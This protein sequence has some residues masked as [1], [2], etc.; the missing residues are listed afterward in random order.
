MTDFNFD[1]NTMTRAYAQ[2]KAL[3]EE[4]NVRPKARPKGIASKP[5]DGNTDTS[6]DE[7]N[8]YDK[9]LD[10]LLGYF[11]NEDEADKV[12]SDKTPDRQDTQ[13]SYEDMFGG[14]SQE[15]IDAVEQAKQ[16]RMGPADR[17]DVDVVEKEVITEEAKPKPLV[18]PKDI[19][20][21]LQ[22]MDPEGIEDMPPL[23]KPATDDGGL[24]SR[25]TSSEEGET[26]T[27]AGLMSDPRKLGGAEGY[28]NP[29]GDLSIFSTSVD[30]LYTEFKGNL[31]GDESHLG[32]ADYKQI[33]ITLPLGIVATSGLKY[34]H[35]GTT[36][37]LPKKLSNR[38]PVLKAAGV[39]TDNFDPANVVTTDAVKDGIKRSD[40][41]S[42]E[43]WTKAIV[44]SFETS[45]IDEM[46]AEGVDTDKLDDSVIEGITSL[47][48][49]ARGHKW[50]DIE[51]GY[52]ELEK[53]NPDM[54]KLQ[55][56][57][58]QVFTSNKI[59]IRGLADRRAKDYNK[60]AE[61]LNQPT[62][63]KYTPKK[64]TNGN[65]GIDYK[66]SDGTTITRDTGRDYATE[67]SKASFKDFLDIEISI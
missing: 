7:P 11:S 54:T 31:E 29:V 38:W 50:S 28:G 51:A 16:K 46:K 13:T 33:G 42:D 57:M 22:R 67:A 1:P 55:S 6:S 49:N 19:A 40:Y 32:G 41:G 47:A 64:L 44:K 10:Q 59:V 14:L 24:M 26:T 18:D 8:F 27:D 21:D 61:G 65:A 60:V 43:T 45:A 4:E 30:N 35:N 52:Q 58:L 36:I 23:P 20:P 5:D 12:L 62:I 3:T 48:W 37:D 63:T 25:D 56:G 53:T 15:T 34:T 39:T 66:L 9:M 2:R 17:L